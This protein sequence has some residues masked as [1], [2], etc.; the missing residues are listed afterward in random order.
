MPGNR[1]DDATGNF[2]SA[3]A[4]FDAYVRQRGFFVFGAVLI[5]ASQARRG[6]VGRSSP[7]ACGA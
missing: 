6:S 2:A 3:G 5:T 7:G 4:F 1:R